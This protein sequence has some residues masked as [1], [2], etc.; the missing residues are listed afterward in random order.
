MVDH[1]LRS[2][3]EQ[4]LEP[5]SRNRNDGRAWQSPNVPHRAPL[6]PSEMSGRLDQ[7]GS[8]S[9]PLLGRVEGENLALPPV[10]SRHIRERAQQSSACGLGDKRRVIQGM[11]QF[12][13]PG[14]SQ[15]VVP[16]RNVCRHLVG[17][18]P[19]TNPHCIN[20]PCPARDS[21]CMRPL[22]GRCRCLLMRK[23]FRSAAGGSE[24]VAAW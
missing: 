22:A 20:A 24:S 16:G 14:R 7:R 23:A 5:H 6:P 19:R 10:L 21:C 17:G 18:L 2:A 1:A 13:Q 3:S 12:P 8:R 9:A 15:I 11:N 4:G